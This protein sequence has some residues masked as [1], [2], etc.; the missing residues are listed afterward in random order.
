MKKRLLSQPWERRYVV[1]LGGKFLFFKDK[2]SY[3]QAPYSPLSTRPTNLIGY[4]LIAGAVE[5]PFTLLLSP[6]DI[7][8]NR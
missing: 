3:E 5:P 7:E 4:T 1:V 8:D 6:L 2:Y